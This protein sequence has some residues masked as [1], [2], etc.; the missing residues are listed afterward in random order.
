MAETSRIQH[1]LDNVL[2]EGVEIV[3]PK[4]RPRFTPRKN[5]LVF[6]SVRG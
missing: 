5:V 3:S 6:D 1:F 2:A 4:R